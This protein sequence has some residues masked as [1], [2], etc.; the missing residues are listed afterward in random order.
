[1]GEE[2]SYGARPATDVEEA[3]ATVEMEVLGESIGQGRGVWFATLPVVAGGAF[4]HGLV[5]D[6]VLPRVARLPSRHVFSVADLHGD[7]LPPHVCI[8][9]GSLQHQ[10]D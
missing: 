10:P 8:L 4:E 9:K 1:M 2:Q 6:P 7:G 3:P 5:P